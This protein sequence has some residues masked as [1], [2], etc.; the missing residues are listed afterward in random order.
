MRLSVGTSGFSYSGWKGPFYPADL[1]ASEMLGYYAERLPA[2]EINN[3]FYRLPRRSVLEGWTAQVPERF[4][5]AIKASQRITHR[6]R[7]REVD[8]ETGYLLDVV[9]ALGDRL[10]VLLFQLPP[11]LAIDLER[12]DRF[13]ALLPAGTPAAFEFRHP[14]WLDPRVHERL[15]ARG[16]AWVVSEGD[17]EPSP[18]FLVTAPFSYLRLRRAGYS[19]EELAAWVARLRSRGLEEAFVF[20]KHEEAGTGPRLAAEFLELAERAGRRR[21]A[22]GVGPDEAA[23]RRGRDT[24]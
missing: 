6:K 15:R 10:G 20:F 4:R 1:A 8:E 19:R 11:N 16:C 23:E 5:F 3:T 12:F 18:D 13:L 14:S 17:G 21:G 7:L 2:V 22:L 9:R 24:G